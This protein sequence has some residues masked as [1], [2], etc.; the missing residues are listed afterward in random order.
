M[1]VSIALIG[2]SMVPGFSQVASL[3]NFSMIEKSDAIEQKVDKVGAL[4]VEVDKITRKYPNATYYYIDN[5]NGGPSDVEIWG[6]SDRMDRESLRT[7][8]VD[9]K[10]LK[11]ELALIDDNKEFPDHYIYVTQPEPKKG[12]TDFYSGINQKISYPDAAIKQGLEGTILVTFKIDE[13]GKI[14]SVTT[15]GNMHSEHDWIIMEMENEV[16][17]AVLET[18]GEWKP[19]EVGEAPI[20]KWLT[21]PVSFKLKNESQASLYPQ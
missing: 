18:S 7:T 3:E 11:D 9:L 19:A 17:M 4:Y 21:L 5:D 20:S 12:Y 2:L 16:R 14:D 10:S 13:E 8:L 6:I 15:T 1:L